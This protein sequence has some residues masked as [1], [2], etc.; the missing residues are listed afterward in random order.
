MGVIR[1]RSGIAFGATM[2]GTSEFYDTMGS[3]YT[4]NRKRSVRG[5]NGSFV[6]NI[7]REGKIVV[8]VAS[9][10]V[11]IVFASRI[12]FER[13]RPEFITFISV[14]ICVLMTEGLSWMINRFC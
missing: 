11:V 4:C 12:C 6:S 14:F 7:G 1:D 8:S 13:W 9:V 5:S 2:V 10:G 3:N